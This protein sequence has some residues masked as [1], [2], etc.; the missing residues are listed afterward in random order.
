MNSIHGIAPIEIEESLGNAVEDFDVESVNDLLYRF[1]FDEDFL[2]DL[3][4]DIVQKDN[5]QDRT[6]IELALILLEKT[7]KQTKEK[8]LSEIKQIDK[9]LFHY[10]CE[11]I[12]L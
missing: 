2:K 5:Y 9:V 12:D 3:S 7:G 6:N 8:F 4:I 11:R 1:T 10:L